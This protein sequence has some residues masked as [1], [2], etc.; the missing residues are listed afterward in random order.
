MPMTL[1]STVTVT[2]ASTNLIEFTN[3][4]QTGKDLLLVV[5]ARR[6][7]SGALWQFRVNNLGTNVYD[8]RNLIGS[9][10]AT[11]STSATGD[12]GVDFTVA[13]S[14]AAANIFGNSQI[15]VT[16]Y[17]SSA[18]KLISVDGVNENNATAA[19]SRLTAGVARTTNPITSIQLTGATVVQNSTASLY[20]IS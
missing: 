18:N 17:T 3:I 4:P 20:I 14:T 6:D 10:S 16:N 2:A 11:S 1:V 19:D 13:R 15:Y 9:G 12:F 7:D 5:S 8:Y